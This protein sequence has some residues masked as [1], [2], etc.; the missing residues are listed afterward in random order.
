LVSCR[1]KDVDSK[2]VHGEDGVDDL[3]AAFVDEFAEA[4]VGRDE[5]LAAF[6]GEEIEL[7]TQLFGG[8]GGFLDESVAALEAE[9]GAGRGDGGEE[10]AGLLRGERVVG[11]RVTPEAPDEATSS[12]D[13][14]FSS[15]TLRTRKRRRVVR[16]STALVRRAEAR[17]AANLS[18]LTD[19]ARTSWQS[20]STKG[21][22]RPR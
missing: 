19:P 20:C 4:L 7:G 2:D 3:V 9:F 13:C 8:G 6:L 14:F 5:L 12:W 18:R 16:V 17:Q 22:L 21:W 11:G 15:M 10:I 1:E